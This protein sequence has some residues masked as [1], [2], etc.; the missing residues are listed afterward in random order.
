MQMR[1]ICGLDHIP[2]YEIATRGT[3]SYGARFARARGTAASSTH[4]LM[5]A[6]KSVCPNVPVRPRLKY[7]LINCDDVT[8]PVAVYEENPESITCVYLRDQVNESV[9]ECCCCNKSTTVD[10]M[11]KH[12]R[13]VATELIARCRNVR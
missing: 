4:Q 13:R 2:R 10:G 12:G 9:I 3:Y 1:T 6:L 7:I 5:N 11:I 8:G